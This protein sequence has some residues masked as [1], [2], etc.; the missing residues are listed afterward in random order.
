MPA[1][2]LTTEAGRR[3]ALRFAAMPGCDEEWA[4]RIRQLVAEAAAADEEG[5]WRRCLL[6]TECLNADCPPP[7]EREEAAS[8][9]REGWQWKHGIEIKNDKLRREMDRCL[10]CG[11]EFRNTIALMLHVREQHESR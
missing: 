1:L 11:K 9:V 10:C 5:N 6:L 2:R 7:K 4:K 8:E 3:A